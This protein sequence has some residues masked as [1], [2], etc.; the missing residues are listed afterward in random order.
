M[1]Q[2]PSLHA[3]SKRTA[4]KAGWLKE[5]DVKTGDPSEGDEDDESD[6]SDWNAKVG[7]GAKRTS[8]PNRD[9][10]L[11]TYETTSGAEE[12]DSDPE[13]RMSRAGN[14]EPPLQVGSQELRYISSPTDGPTKAEEEDTE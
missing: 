4:K 3:A 11:S 9:I 10:G 12:N 2:K 13:D 5:A 14:N 7:I 6:W 1:G 8:T